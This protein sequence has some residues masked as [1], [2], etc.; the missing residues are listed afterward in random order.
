MSQTEP[1][2][3]ASI[4]IPEPLRPAKEYD[5]WRVCLRPEA[6]GLAGA[7]SKQFRVTAE[8]GV[9]SLLTT[10]SHSLGESEQVALPHG[11]FSPPLN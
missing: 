2:N 10:V 3:E 6:L 9:M 4:E 8:E 5:D 11:N 7:F 1:E